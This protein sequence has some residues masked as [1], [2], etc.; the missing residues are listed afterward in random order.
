MF[1]NEVF[2]TVKYWIKNNKMFLKKNFFLI[3]VLCN[4][5]HT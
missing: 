2:I 5:L 4:V 3:I 1:T